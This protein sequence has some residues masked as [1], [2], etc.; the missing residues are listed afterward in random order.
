[1]DKTNIVSIGSILDRCEPERI[2]G[3]KYNKKVCE[4]YEGNV[5]VSGQIVAI[6][7]FGKALF[8]ILRDISGEIQIFCRG[9]LLT[10]Y[11]YVRSISVGDH[12]SVLGKVIVTSIKDLTIEA[13]EIEKG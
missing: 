3:R 1:M 8:Y 7:D 11:E 6:R 4:L 2:E 13:I 10:N 9:N 12:I 5:L